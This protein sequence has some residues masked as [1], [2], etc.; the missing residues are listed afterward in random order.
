[1]KEH[2]W[3]LDSDPPEAAAARVAGREGLGFTLGL[4][5]PPSLHPLAVRDRIHHDWLGFLQEL[6]GH[7]PAALLIEDL[8]WASDELCD[9]L[10]VLAER[11]RGP[12]LMIV[13]ARPELL[14]QRPGLA[15]TAKASLVRLEA[16]SPGQ[17]QE[18]IGAL[19][20]S[21]CPGSIRELV[22]R[23]GEGNAVFVEDLIATLPDWRVL[24]RSNGVW[25][26]RGLPAGFSAPDTVQALLA[27]RIDML[28]R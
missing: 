7:Q 17:A 19:L 9:L 13:T 2:F 26:F 8:H 16:L 23:R 21:D 10:R 24:A 1:L 27:A 12:L 5:P 11:V 25:W 15:G 4:A 6:T 28:P 22:A 18:L 3:I 14:D 20:G